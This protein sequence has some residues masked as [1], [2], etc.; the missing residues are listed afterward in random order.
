MEK[1]GVQLDA[2]PGALDQPEV[3]LHVV[4]TTF[5]RNVQQHA[6]AVHLENVAPLVSGQQAEQY[7]PVVL[8]CG[9]PL[10]RLKKKK[11]PGLETV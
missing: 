5:G 7:R 11:K 9:Q 2:L 10:V 4:P 6:P 8:L 1:F 3:A